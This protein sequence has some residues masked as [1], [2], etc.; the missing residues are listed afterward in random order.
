MRGMVSTTAG[1]GHFGPLIPFG[2][3]C[4]EAGH[5]VRVAAPASFAGAVA[6]AGFEHAPFA[7]V[8]SE[9]MGP[10]FSRLPRAL[11]GGGQRDGDRRDLRPARRP[12]R[13]PRASWQ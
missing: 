11:V 7:D 10:I 2:V 8:A 6:G 3:A 12:G 9:V 13:P 5:D 1:S 4:R